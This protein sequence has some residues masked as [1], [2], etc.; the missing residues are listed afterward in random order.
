MK[1]KLVVTTETR[2]AAMETDLA[3][4]KGMLRQILLANSPASLTVEEKARIITAA[5]RKGK[6]ALKEATRLINGEA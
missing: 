1:R 3:E 2:L 4:I 6:Q 5:M